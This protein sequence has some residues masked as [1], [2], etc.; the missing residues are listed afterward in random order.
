MKEYKL[1]AVVSKLVKEG[2]GSFTKNDINRYLDTLSNNKVSDFRVSSGTHRFVTNRGVISERDNITGGVTLKISD[3]SIV[4]EIEVEDKTKKVIASKVVQ[5]GSIA[6][7]VG[8]TKQS[9]NDYKGI[10]P[11]L[12]LNKIKEAWKSGQYKTI[13]SLEPTEGQEV[14]ISSVEPVPLPKVVDP[15]F[16]GEKDDSGVMYYI[17]GWFEDVTLGRHLLEGFLLDEN[18]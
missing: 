10:P 13:S 5:N 18:V 1:T 11:I 14:M 6:K 7:R 2:N 12:A 9:M 3:E 16:V 8:I 15:I 4:P 17:C